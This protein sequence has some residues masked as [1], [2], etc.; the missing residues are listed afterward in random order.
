MSPYDNQIIQV[1]IPPYSSPL[2]TGAPFL[3][4]APPPWNPIFLVQPGSVSTQIST[5]HLIPVMP[6]VPT[7]QYFLSIPQPSKITPQV[8]K[9]IQTLSQIQTSQMVPRISQ[10]SSTQPIQGELQ[11]PLNPIG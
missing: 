11:D 8:S 3:G 1:G 4:M 9:P 6:Q 5:S 10:I 2:P 7:D